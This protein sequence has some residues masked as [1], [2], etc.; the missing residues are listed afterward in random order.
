MGKQKEETPEPQSKL[1]TE[2]SK[3]VKG[4]HERSLMRNEKRIH[5]LELE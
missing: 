5:I 1:H 4:K 3:I 2:E